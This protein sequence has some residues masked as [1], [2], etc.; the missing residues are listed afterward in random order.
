MPYRASSHLKMSSTRTG[1]RASEVGPSDVA[2]TAAS[3]WQATSY[4]TA[5]FPCAARCSKGSV[6]I[7][8]GTWTDA[9]SK[10][11]PGSG[12]SGPAEEEGAGTSPPASSHTATIACTIGAGSAATVT[13]EPLAR[14]GLALGARMNLVL[15]IATGQCGARR[16]GRLGARS[17]STP[18]AAACF[19]RNSW[20]AS[21]SSASSSMN[22]HSLE[23]CPMASSL[24]MP[25]RPGI[26]DKI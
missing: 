2:S 21:G 15:T 13:A 17:R 12:P 1:R 26:L 4:T 8:R 10:S 18:A 9:Q 14:G 6:R 20:Y 22:S 16:R 24:L 5:D 19:R 25:S 23:A 3:L 7:F 11:G